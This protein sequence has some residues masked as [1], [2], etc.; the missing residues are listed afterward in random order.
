MCAGCSKNWWR[1][2]FQEWIHKLFLIIWTLDWVK[3]VLEIN[4][5]HAGVHLSTNYVIL[6]NFWRMSYCLCASANAHSQ[7]QTI[8]QLSCF[9]FSFTCRALLLFLFLFECFMETASDQSFPKSPAF[10]RSK[11]SARRW[12]WL[13]F[14]FLPPRLQARRTHFETAK[15]ILQFVNVMQDAKETYIA[16]LPC[17]IIW[18]KYPSQ[19]WLLV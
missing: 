6:C 3:S 8:K 18:N 17:W 13:R 4:L 19:N 14:C 10:Q 2:Q 1:R 9:R 15:K 7:L 16:N 12:S 11:L 5:K